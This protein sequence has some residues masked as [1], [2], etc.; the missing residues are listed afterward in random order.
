[1]LKHIFYSGLE[2]SLSKIFFLSKSFSLDINC[3]LLI[4]HFA[5][6]CH[7]KHTFFISLA[8][9]MNNSKDNTF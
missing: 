4:F 7:K 6:A 1:M 8:E 2:Q 5:F 9:C 3:F